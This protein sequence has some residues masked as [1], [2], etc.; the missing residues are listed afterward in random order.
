MKQPK[1]DIFISYSR[2]D[3]DIV[4]RVSEELI[5][6]GFSV[7]IDENG[8]ESGDAFKSVIVR[9]IENCN[10]VLFFS[11]QSSNES[12]WTTKEISVAIYE[13]KNIIPV[14]LDDSKYNSEIKF[15]LINLDYIDMS[16]HT[17][18]NEGIQRVIKSLR[19]HQSLNT[20]SQIDNHSD[21]SE[22]NK[23]GVSSKANFKFLFQ[24]KGCLISLTLCL[25]GIIVVP[26][27]F[28]HNTSQSNS[29]SL[30]SIPE[31]LLAE[32]PNTFSKEGFI[33]D[34]NYDYSDCMYDAMEDTAA[35][36]MD[37][38]PD[39]NYP[40]PEE[41]EYI[42]Y[43]KEGIEFVKN[44]NYVEA[45]KQFSKA[46][47]LDYA[48]AIYNVSICHLTGLGAEVDTIK[49]IQGLQKAIELDS[50]PAKVKLESLNIK[51]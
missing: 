7:W 30:S 48:D 4:K 42:K 11:S 32:L 17:L 39:F 37:N 43:M 28:R 26:F 27:I 31:D 15:D 19:N 49:A 33:M 2:Q 9:A 24:Y 14:K 22:K 51:Q 1:Y 40:E 47:N 10:T 46:A 13:G 21:I 25:L 3:S 20:E 23:T 41:P 29:P 50:E 12:Y 35:Y 6:T 16:N 8:I 44:E 5:S 38:L 45:Y 34:V 18:I 36:D